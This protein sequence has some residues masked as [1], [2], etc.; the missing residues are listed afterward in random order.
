MAIPPS[1]CKMKKLILP[2]LVI[3]ALAACQK[4]KIIPG[5]SA[6]GKDTIPDGASF[7]LQ[8]QTDSTGNQYPTN[9]SINA[10]VHFNHT[11]HLDFSFYSGEDSGDQNADQNYS[12]WKF[13]AVSRDGGL[14]RID[15]VPYKPGVDVPLYI[16]SAT[17][18]NY[19]QHFILYALNQVNIPSDIHIWVKDNLMKDS[20]DIRNKPYRF[21]IHHLDTNS[22]GGNRFKVVLEPY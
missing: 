5:P 17:T 1:F 14:L 13:D 15:G 12:G 4:N 9:D 11:Y 2:A 10:W 21:Y 20:A 16:W 18:Y 8:M 22:F 19:G 7:K 3:I 6:V